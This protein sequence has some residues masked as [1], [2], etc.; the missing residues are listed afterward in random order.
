MRLLKLTQMANAKWL[1]SL[2]MHCLGCGTRKQT[3]LFICKDVTIGNMKNKHLEDSPS[4]D[5]CNSFKRQVVSC[6]RR[7]REVIGPFVQENTVNGVNYLDMLEL[8]VS[9]TS[10]PQVN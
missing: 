3:E 7:A 8:S 10:F 6:I 2:Q 4:S 1:S 9:Y 5:G